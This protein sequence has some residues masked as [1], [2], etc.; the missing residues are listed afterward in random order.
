MTG[1]RAIT[2]AVDYSDL[3]AATLPYNRHHF[4]EVYVVTDERSRDSVW[5][6]TAANHSHCFVT[7]AF[8]RNGAKFNKW[9]ALEESLD[10]MGRH[11]WL[12]VMDADVLWPKDAFVEAD[13]YTLF[14]GRGGEGKEYSSMTVG[15]LLS[16][17]RRMCPWP[18]SEH[19]GPIGV[20]P[21]DERDWHIYPVHRNVGEWAGYTQIFH[22]ADPHLP[23]PPW[24]QTDW[25]HA[26]GADSFF[27]ARWPHSAK[28]R[29]AWEVLH[30]GEAGANWF[31]RA[32]PMADGGV[33]ADAAEK[34]ELVR[35]VWRGRADRRRRGLTGDDVFRPER[36]G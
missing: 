30:L 21:P 23:A 2:V 29:P 25:V 8:Y 26:G 3:L 16:P 15:G 1:L 10:R 18:V 19:P 5:K 22:A 31:G 28:R 32:T 20:M 12:C 35:E 14:Y 13:G 4:D 36:L 11:G 27:Q 6:I 7:D 17:L 24:H 9:A 33:P 34:G